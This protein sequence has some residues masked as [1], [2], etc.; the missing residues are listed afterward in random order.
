MDEADGKSF[1]NTKR[2]ESTS[3]K[4]EINNATIFREE[5]ARKRSCGC[6]KG[7]PLPHVLGSGERVL[8]GIW[9]I[10]FFFFLV[11]CSN[12][13]KTLHDYRLV[14]QYI[15]NEA[16]LH[17]LSRFRC[18]RPSERCRLS[19]P[20]VAMQAERSDKI[21]CPRRPVEASYRLMERA[22]ST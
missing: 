15:K 7:L 11:H 14:A 18:H 4:H 1:K 6:E 5:G 22:E 12:P 3:S 21:S 2:V 13:F 16:I 17:I 19:R 8:R 20:T 9:R 10:F